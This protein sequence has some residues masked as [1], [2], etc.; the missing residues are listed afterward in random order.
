MTA[1][2]HRYDTD[3]SEAEWALLAPLLPPA[4]PGGRPR[5]NDLRE[6][7]N[8]IRYVLRTGAAWRHVPHDLPHW[9]LCYQW[10]RLWRRDGSWQ[11]WQDVVRE[12]VRQQLGRNPQPSAAILDTQSVKTTEKGGLHAAMTR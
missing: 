3:L 2:R 4:K 1:A 12:R 9:N 11:R 7:I 8:G 6:V 5:E 10:F